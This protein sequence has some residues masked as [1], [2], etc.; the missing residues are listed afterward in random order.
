ML[1]AIHHE[2]DE[3]R[4]K[5]AICIRKAIIA[6]AEGIGA[7]LQAIDHH[8][9]VLVRDIGCAI[10]RKDEIVLL[11]HPRCHSSI[12]HGVCLRN[13]LIVGRFVP[14]V[15]AERQVVL[16]PGQVVDEHISRLVGSRGEAAEV[17]ALARCRKGCIVCRCGKRAVVRLD[18]RHEISAKLIDVGREL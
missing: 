16:E 3:V 4:G 2:I 7:L 18:C 17:A 5:R 1:V 12:S 14:H 6:R 9:H 8:A 11:R 13:A 15:A 10:C